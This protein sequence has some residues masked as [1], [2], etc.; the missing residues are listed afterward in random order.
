M[1]KRKEQTCTMC[2]TAIDSANG[3]SSTSQRYA[4]SIYMHHCNACIK[5]VYL[6]YA[7]KFDDKARAFFELCRIYDIPY[8]PESVPSEPEM[9][10]DFI[11]AW[12]FY[13]IGLGKTPGARKL[14]FFGGEI[15]TEEVFELEYSE[16]EQTPERQVEAQR[17]KG[18]RKELFRRYGY[19]PD[20]KPRD[21]VQMEEYRKNVLAQN[22]NAS[23]FQRQQVDLAAM[24]YLQSMN[25]L[26][27]EDP[28]AV[29]KCTN[30]IDKILES[31]QL[32][33]KDLSKDGEDITMGNIVQLCEQESFIEPWK[34]IPHYPI[35]RDM[36]DYA[37]MD[38]INQG[39][40]NAG[41][42]A[43]TVLP[44]EYKHEDKLGEFDKRRKLK[45]NV[46]ANMEYQDVEIDDEA[47]EAGESGKNGN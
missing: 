3:T 16:E 25:A 10:K 31:A 47:D 45:K 11:A 34:Y 13:N 27:E 28:G 20:Y 14:G 29:A 18:V 37:L 15:T 21:Y 43:F 32:R 41:K 36:A 40:R 39:R 42:T 24:V 6:G 30:A 17:P 22:P 1:T 23:T 12:K 46:M 33:T 44:P 35:P 38:I 26:R 7:K 2:G 8:L 4:W 19:N 9:S 5:K